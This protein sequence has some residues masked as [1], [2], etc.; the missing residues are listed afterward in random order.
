MPRERLGVALLFPADASTAIDVLRRAMGADDLERLPPHLTLVPPVNVRV[1]DLD[2]ACDLLRDAARRTA[3]FRLT[4]GPARTFLPINPVLYLEVGGDVPSVDALRDRIFRPPLERNLTWPFQPHVTV[5]DGGEETRI[6]AAVDALAGVRI[7]VDITQVHLLKEHNDDGV[8]CWRPIFEA[9]LGE[10]AVVGRGGLELELE[11]GEKPY[12]GH[13][14][15]VTARRD[16]RIVG[17]AVG[18]TDGER[19]RLLDVQV[20]PDARGQGVGAHLVAAFASAAAERGATTI[21]AVDHPFLD[22][23]GFVEGRRAL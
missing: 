2:D 8:R 23:L 16:G 18:W 5:L 17:T 12:A 20:E 7:D 14:L 11:V 4:L 22:R 9:S 10:P 19:A 13:S 3:P 1:E 21:D 15:G 6:R